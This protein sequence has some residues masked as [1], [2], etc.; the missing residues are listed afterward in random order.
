MTEELETGVPYPRFT[1]EAI[2]KIT[3]SSGSWTGQIIGVFQQDLPTERRILLGRYNRNYRTFYNTFATCEKNGRYYAL[4]SEHYTCT[5]IMEII[6]NVGFQDIGGEDPASGGFCP[7]DYYIPRIMDH[8]PTHGFVSGCYWG[9]EWQTQYLDLTNIDKGIIY[10]SPEFGYG[11]EFNF[12]I[13]DGPMI[14]SVFKDQANAGYL[15]VVSDIR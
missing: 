12:I 15:K 1:A 3:Y 14:D 2:D 6:P 5:R 4:Y 7:A 8:P 9:D 10:R 13:P 11:G